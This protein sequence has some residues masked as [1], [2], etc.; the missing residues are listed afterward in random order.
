VTKARTL[1]VVA[2]ERECK[3]WLQELD[4]VLQHVLPSAEQSQV[5]EPCTIMLLRGS[6]GGV[7]T[8]GRPAVQLSGRW[9]HKRFPARLGLRF[10]FGEA[11]EMSSISPG[12]NPHPR[13][14]EGGG[15]VSLC[16]L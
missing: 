14:R 7:Y 9:L 10:G 15:F 11:I 12:P 4:F 3:R 13:G 6:G 8:Y 1:S 5:C 2:P 16:P